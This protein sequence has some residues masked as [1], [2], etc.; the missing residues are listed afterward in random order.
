VKLPFS[1]A[2]TPRDQLQ[3]R[4]LS[5]AAVF[6]LLFSAILTLSPAV[7]VHGWNT[8]L[9]WE[10]WIG[11]LVWV[12]GFAFLHIQSI[13]WLPDRDPYMLPVMALICGWGLLTIYRLIPEF[14]FR[15]TVWLALSVGVI[16][17]GMRFQ[18]VLQMLRR[19]KY[20]LLVGGLLLTA[21]TIVFGTYPGGQG[22]R[23]WLGCCG[24]FF[25][26]SEPLKL[27]LVIYLAAYLADRLPTVFTLSEHLAPTVILVGTAALL[28][29]AQ[30]DLGTAILLVSIYTL[31]VYIASGRRRI[32]I[33]A[34][35]I[36]LVIS[37]AGYFAFDVIRVRVNAWLNPWIDASGRSYQIVQSLIALAS[38]SVFG[39]GPGLGSPGLVPL[40]HS[41]FITAA[42]AEETGFLG[43]SGLLVLY[44]LLVSRG[45]LTALHARSN[46]RRYLAAGV[47]VLFAVQSLL[48]ISG[49]IRLL[50]LTGVTL[51]LVSYGGS[52]LLTASFAFALLLVC[53]AH[54]EEEPAP[55]SQA[56]SFT[57]VNSGILA[58]I[59]L[60]S[61][62][63]GWWAFFQSGVLQARP[64]NPRR[65]IA[66]RY[67][68]RG[69]IFDR[70]N[71]P[72]VL[73]EGQRGE[74][75]RNTVY[76]LLG[77]VTG[78]SNLLYGR[79]GLEASLNDYLR[80]L[81]GTPSSSIMTHQLLYNQPPAGL[82]VRLSL[83]LDYQQR[84]DNL[85]GDRVGAAVVLNA[86][87]GEI[88]AL[89]SHPS[90]DP[91]QLEELWPQLVQDPDSPLLNR[92]SQGMYPLGGAIGPF[93][94]ARVLAT[95]DLPALP[96]QL[97]Y[98][99]GDQVLTC[100]GPVSDPPTWSSALVNSCPAALVAASR[101]IS[102]SQFQDLHRQLGFYSA[103]EIEMPAAPPSAAQTPASAALAAVGQTELRV[104][105]LQLALAAATISNQGVRPPAR[106]VLAVQ[107]P[108]EGWVV[109]PGGQSTSVFTQE[110]V[111]ETALLLANPDIPI[112][113]TVATART[114]QGT[115]TWYLAGTLP[116]WLGSPLSLALVLEEDNPE[117]ARE[118]G[119][120]VF[121]T[122]L[123]S[124]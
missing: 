15:Q 76:P 48:I 72:I 95:T 78:Y 122:A 35:V 4:L 40:S 28:L 6:L 64:D 9:R 11:F 106:L 69:P 83:D 104:S 74:L 16:W 89:A 113:E 121:R 97:S 30:R 110:G 85:L 12:A 87:T 7:R 60:V 119:L 33:I 84:L 124:E 82:A 117:A 62:A 2:P 10:H 59:F 81:D 67:S 71:N 17:A 54:G 114:E 63:A 57:L 99:A 123:P 39:T 1:L 20:L 5:L 19:Y 50:P 105:P 109:R 51:P 56:R 66:D 116:N 55:L 91:N 112:W 29:A 70:Q 18:V 46:Y 37:V 31:I 45:M 86:R 77:N 80:G 111:A 75:T 14:G 118:I 96:A 24:Y 43:L 36:M 90:Y 120:N 47:S 3:G 88:L 41:D 22:P 8:S 108:T 27:L 26:P 58:G 38:G 115:I 21:A 94:L 25:Q 65:F 44:A 34:A 23:L 102:S 42:I 61:L 103:P 68:P 98:Q 107:T 73:T 93:I 79:A 100:S 53:S 49:N 101:S 52:S 32:L 13:R 92:S